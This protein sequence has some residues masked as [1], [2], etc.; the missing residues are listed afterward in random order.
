MDNDAKMIQG[1]SNALIDL[2]VKYRSSKIQD[3]ML[4]RPA[5]EEVLEDFYKYQIRLL[6]EGT[7]TTPADLEQMEAIKAEIQAAA[8]KQKLIAAIGK[9]IGF[10]ATKVV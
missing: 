6:K 2:Q 7:L 8:S 5:L 1:L 10:I 4:I 9:T 3:R